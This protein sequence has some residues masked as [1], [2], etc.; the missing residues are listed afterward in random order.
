MYDNLYINTILIN[1]L[2]QN[3]AVVRL[4]K[5]RLDKLLNDEINAYHKVCKIEI[6]LPIIN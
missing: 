1:C 4:K 6:N 2:S 3:N 5:L